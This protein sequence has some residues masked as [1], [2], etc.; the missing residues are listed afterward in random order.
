M[1]GAVWL[2]LAD[3]VKSWAGEEEQLWRAATVVAESETDSD[4]TEEAPSSC[5]DGPIAGQEPPNER[6]LRRWRRRH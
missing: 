2:P 3:S 4:G 1:D 5:G 6:E